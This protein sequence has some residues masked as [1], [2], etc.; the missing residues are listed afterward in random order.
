MS[1]INEAFLYMNNTSG[2]AFACMDNLIHSNCPRLA[3]LNDQQLQPL[4]ISTLT[5]SHSIGTWLDD[6][7]KL[8]PASGE[9]RIDNS[10]R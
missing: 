2:E 9:A 6:F 5:H 1:P 7:R 4:W 8:D 3:Y 10:V